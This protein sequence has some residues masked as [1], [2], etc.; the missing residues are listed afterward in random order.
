[1]VEKIG[2]IKNPLTIIAIFAGIAEVSGTV[3]LPFVDKTNQWLFICF[4][5]SF[6]IL[7][8]GLFFVTLNFN[9]KA[10]Y[11]PSDYQDEKNYILTNRYDMSRQRN[12]EVEVVGNSNL[13]KITELENTIEQLSRRVNG[14]ENDYNENKNQIN[15][16]EEDP[17]YEFFVSNFKNVSGFITSMEEIDAHFKV[18]NS[19]GDDENI[20]VSSKQYQAIW[21]G[22]GIPLKLAQ[23]LIAKAKEYYPHLCYID[24]YYDTV[25]INADN[26]FYVGGATDS[27]VRFNLR[28]LENE[29]FE[30]LQ[31]FTTLG[32]FH[33]FIESL[34][35]K[36]S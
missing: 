12:I 4:L 31:K 11:A 6:P 18:Y 1:M 20:H 17:I 9:N 13:I 10:L 22:P 35:I 26:V 15:A 33:R 16:P 19:P 23:A 3:V 2:T 34:K 28:I 8:I 30:D 25:E 7:L 24:L 32:E 29:D 36:R 5:I 21:I 14:W 27:A